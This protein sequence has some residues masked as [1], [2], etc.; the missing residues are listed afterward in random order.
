MCF[1]YINT[2]EFWTLPL[3]LLNTSHFLKGKNNPPRATETIHFFQ[4]EQ[5]RYP[6]KATLPRLQNGNNHAY[7]TE[8]L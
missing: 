3:F 1:Q 7:F 8:L 4:L 6:L 2:D 5:M